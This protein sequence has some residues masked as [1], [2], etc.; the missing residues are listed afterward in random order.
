MKSTPQQ[1]SALIHK[2]VEQYKSTPEKS[3]EIFYQ[4]PHTDAAA[5]GPDFIRADKSRVFFTFYNMPAEKYDEEYQSFANAFFIQS[6]QTD[7]TGKINL[8]LNVVMPVRDGVVDTALMTEL[9]SHELRHAYRF[10]SEYKQG[11]FK[12]G[13]NILNKLLGKPN[14]YDRNSAYER[15]MPTNSGTDIDKFRWVGYTFNN[16]ELNATL[17][18]IE[19]F[20]YETKNTDLTHSRGQQLINIATEHLDWIEQN[21]DDELWKR[22]IK[23]ASYLPLLKDE[24]LSHFKKRWL[25]YYKNQLKIYN[26]KRQKIIDKYTMEKSATLQNIEIE[27]MR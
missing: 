15:S 16:D 22:A 5:M 17:A 27:K 7:K 10:Y 24:T 3:D 19:G 11:H 25:N 1:I 9:I 6:G 12:L 2:Y 23:N 13:R 26:H 18:G 8:Q 20:I 14:V 21:A 4:L